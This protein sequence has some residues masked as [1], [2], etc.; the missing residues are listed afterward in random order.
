LYSNQKLALYITDKWIRIDNLET[1]YTQ[2]FS[3]EHLFR[4]HDL[5]NDN[6]GVIDEKAYLYIGLNRAVNDRADVGRGLCEAQVSFLNCY[7]NEEPSMDVDVKS[8]SYT[9]NDKSTIEWVNE[10]RYLEPTPEHPACSGEG[11]LK[12]KFETNGSKKVARF[13]FELGD[14]VSGFTFNIGDSPTNNGYGKK[15]II[16]KNNIKQ[17][18]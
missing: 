1:N 10:L 3:G 2:I 7:A 6:C 14:N 17:T 11:V 8:M 18:N 4:F 9:N 12:L 15:K 5:P 16:K 13:D